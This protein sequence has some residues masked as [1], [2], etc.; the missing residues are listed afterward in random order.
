MSKQSWI[1]QQDSL[2]SALVEI[3]GR[4]DPQALAPALLFGSSAFVGLPF[5][6]LRRI[7][8]DPD[9]RIR[10]I[11]LDDLMASPAS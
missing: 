9:P 7:C 3:I 2:R 10:S 8:R 6:A 1:A 4:A 11:Q 5:E